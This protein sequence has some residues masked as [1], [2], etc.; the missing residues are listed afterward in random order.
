VRERKGVLVQAH[1]HH[2]TEYRY[3]EP[4]FDS[5]N[6][7]RLKPIEDARQSVLSFQLQLEPNVPMYSHLDYYG[8]TLHHFHV[9]EKH[10]VLRIE[11]RALVVTHAMTQ[12]IGQPA[13]VLEPHKL[14]NIEYLTSSRR[15]PLEFDWASILGWHKLEATEDYVA[16]LDGLNSHLHSRFK[17]QSGF[18]KVDT[19]L[20]EFVQGGIGVCQDYAHAMLAVARSNGIP[21]RYVS[22]YVYAGA[23]FVGA[24]ATHAWL[25]C[26]IPG[27]GWLGFDPTNNTRINESHIK[28]GHGRDYD[29]VPPL[30]G[31]RRG[32]GVESIGVEVSVDV[33]Q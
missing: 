14:P 21:A 10:T 9:L 2:I 26:L 4:A 32:G 31:L 6:E 24:E 20:L 23:D 30:R 27:Y 3:P 33:Q 7:L 11:T 17:Y 22:G 1:I 16:Y 5:F 28:I 13:S 15:V 18:T 29:D 19:P 12:P 25:E 8:T